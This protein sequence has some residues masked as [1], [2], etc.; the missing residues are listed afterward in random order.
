MTSLEAHSADQVNGELARHRQHNTEAS[1]TSM[2]VWARSIGDRNPKYV[3]ES[4]APTGASRFAAHP[5]WLY[6]VHDTV[7]NVG[8]PDM[9]PLIAGTNWTFF[10]PVRVGDK[11]STEARVLGQRAVNGRFAGPSIL[12]TVEL[13]FIGAHDEPVARAVTTLMRVSPAEARRM[14]KFSAWRRY[15]YTRD[16]LIAIEAAYDAEEVQGNSPRYVDDVVAGQMLPGIVRGPVT[17]E[18]VVLFVG[19][20]RPIPSLGAFTHER[21]AGRALGFIHP[22]T[23]TWE[24]H[25][26]GLVDDE[27]ARQLGFPAAH[28]YGIDRI[29]QLSSLIGNWI[30]DSGRIVTLNARLNEPNMLGDTTWFNGR[31]TNVEAISPAQAEKRM[32]RAHLEVRGLNQ[33]GET[34]V[35]GIACVE[36]PLRQLP[37]SEMN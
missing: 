36:L 19:S 11:L 28:D 23:G 32:G 14:G 1:S 15:K 30:G 25:A 20:T 29:S 35:S 16:E 22:R 21:M 7:L 34:S 26:A 10:R 8:P 3:N 12:Q 2:R 18:E 13:E 5:C 24:T 27:S 31:V 9:C 37:L 6:S 17:S 4:Y 33:R